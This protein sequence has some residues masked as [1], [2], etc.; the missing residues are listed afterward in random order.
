VALDLIEK[1]EVER[2][3]VLL[4]A[5]LRGYIENRFRVH[6]PERTTEEFLAE[7][8]ANPALEG[9]RA[10]LG[11]FLALSD[12]VKFA[13]YEPEA[14]DIQSAFDVVKRF[15]AETSPEARQ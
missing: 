12:K 7:A 5:I 15:V 3:F 6:A 11:E 4:S 9:H 1:G 8:S 14:A 13:R 2:F 10:R